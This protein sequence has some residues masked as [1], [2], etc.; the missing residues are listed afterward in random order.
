MLYIYLY[1]LVS[2]DLINMGASLIQVTMV[3]GWW[4]KHR[5]NPIELSTDSMCPNHPKNHKVTLSH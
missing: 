4:E 1:T 2:N 5:V 3:V